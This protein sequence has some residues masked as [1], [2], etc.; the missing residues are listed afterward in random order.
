METVTESSAKI[1]KQ[2][3]LRSEEEFQILPCSW[4]L[5]PLCPSSFNRERSGA[6]GVPPQSLL[7]T[8]DCDREMSHLKRY[9]A[10]LIHFVAACQQIKKPALRE[11]S[12]VCGRA[13]GAWP[14]GEPLLPTGRGQ[15][16]RDEPE[17]PQR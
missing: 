9:F 10:I 5:S 12:A 14:R 6:L 13:S 1:G 2:A 16:L 3:F 11:A 7:Y 8:E 15:P 17:S 4:P